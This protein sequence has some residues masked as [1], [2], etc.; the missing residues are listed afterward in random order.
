MSWLCSPSRGFAYDAANELWFGSLDQV[1]A[2]SSSLEELFEALASHTA[3]GASTI[4]VTT[5][6]QGL[7]RDRP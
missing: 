3:R 4:L 6:I 2:A 5:V 7:G 1:A